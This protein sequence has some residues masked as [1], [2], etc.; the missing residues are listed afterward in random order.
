MEQVE[1]ELLSDTQFIPITEDTVE[2]EEFSCPVCYTDGSESGLV[3]PSRCT[4]RI[5]LECYTNIATRA[6]SPTCPLCR[7]EYLRASPPQPNS[8]P[9]PTPIS[10]PPLR[11]LPRPMSPNMNSDVMSLLIHNELPTYSVNNIIINSLADIERS[12]IIL[13]LL[14]AVR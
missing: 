5:C 3:S 1:S 11:P 13:D 14:N 12:Q 4:H 10:T 8:T 6:P 7:T 2:D 9:Q